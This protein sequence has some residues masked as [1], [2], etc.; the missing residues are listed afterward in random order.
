M[1]TAYRRHLGTCPHREKGQAYTL[2]GCPIWCYGT[3]NGQ[4]IRRSIGTSDSAKALR[5]IARIEAGDDEL[6]NDAP[7]L[8]KAIAAFLASCSSRNLKA[9]TIESY[10]RTLSHLEDFTTARVSTIGTVALDAYRATREVKPGTW[11]KEL[12]TLRAFFAWC[13][14]RDW[15]Q[16]NPAAAL[17][18]PRTEELVTQPFTGDEVVAMIDACSKI[19]SDNPSETDYVRRR[20]R[21]L[22]YTLLYS[23]LRVSDVATLERSALNGR[24]LTL[25]VLKNGVP[26]KALLHQK[27]AEALTSLP[28]ANPKYFFWTGNGTLHS[29]TNNMRVTLNR[30][31]KIAQVH[32]HPHRF[33]DTFAVELLTGGADIRTVQKLLGHTS[34]RTTEKHYAHFVAAHQALLDSAASTL[35]FERSRNAGPLLVHT[36]KNRRRNP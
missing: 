16:K 8:P 11:R 26:L 18:M 22:V 4:R 12:E 17:K 28:S 5:K 31:G 2:C 29:I 13:L 9:S 7:E 25:R 15:I 1:L 23:G 14:E 35:D 3:V 20:A 24:H 19:A 30:L 6:P 27:A 36:I 33:R 21:A 10:R 32:A 34:V